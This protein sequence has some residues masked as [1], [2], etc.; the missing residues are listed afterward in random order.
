MSSCRY[1]EAMSRQCC[2]N[3]RKL[4]RRLHDSGWAPEKLNPR[5]TS[6]A[7]GAITAAALHGASLVVLGGPTLPF[8]ADEMAV[9][10]AFVAEV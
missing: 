9:L 3:C 4:A 2:I 8:T 1:T 6:L 10:R 5:V 7:F